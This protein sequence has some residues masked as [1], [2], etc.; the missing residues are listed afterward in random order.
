MDEG[1]EEGEDEEEEL[2]LLLKAALSPSCVS[3]LSTCTRSSPVTPSSS[4]RW[5]CSAAST[6][7]A[8][9]RADEGWTADIRAR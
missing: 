3:C 2:A 6:C 7:M 9:D 8:V 5:S 4:A 1:E